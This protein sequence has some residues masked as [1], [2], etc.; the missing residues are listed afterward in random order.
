MSRSRLLWTNHN[1]PGTTIDREGH[2]GV[3]DLRDTDSV[4]LAL[5]VADPAAASGPSPNLHVS[6]EV[7][8]A[9]AAWF[10]VATVVSQG[11]HS[12]QQRLVPSMDHKSAGLHLADTVDSYGHG[13]GRV[14]PVVLPEFG[15][16]HWMVYDGVFRNATISL[17]GR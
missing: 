11:G 13:A 9:G 6:L 3:I 2:S 1:T 5:A 7:S 15:R 14:V 17:Y 8:D 4:W 12:W 10:G 16:I